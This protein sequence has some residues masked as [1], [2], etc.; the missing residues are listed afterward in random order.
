MASN[1]IKFYSVNELP[2]NVDPNAIY[3][4]TNGE[5]LKGD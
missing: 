2:T 3:F 5:L 1:T 4:I